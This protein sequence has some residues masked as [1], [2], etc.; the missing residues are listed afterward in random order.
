VSGRLQAP[1]ASPR[2]KSPRYP[3]DRSCWAPESVWTQRKIFDPTGTQ[4]PI[5][6]LPS[7]QPVV[8]TA[9]SRATSA[10][11][12]RS[13][14]AIIR[15]IL[16]LPPFRGRYW[17][18]E[19]FCV[20]STF[21]HPTS[22]SSASMLSATAVPTCS[23]FHHCLYLVAAT[24]QSS[25]EEWDSYHEVSSSSNRFGSTSVLNKHHAVQVNC[26]TRLRHCRLS[27]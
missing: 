26:R 1:A 24:G 15:L 25:A 14:F 6:R 3:L 4:I 9:L 5:P 11:P 8:L 12:D 10:S 2:E 17:T 16:T 7:T 20:Y 22:I 27:P 13:H 19:K 18:T 21:R 23:L